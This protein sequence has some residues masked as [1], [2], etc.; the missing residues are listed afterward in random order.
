MDIGIVSNFIDEYN[1]GIGV[2]THQ[3][4]KNLGRMDT[5]NN[6]HLIHYLKNN[7]DIYSQNS[8]II[9]PKNRFVKGWGSYMFWRHFT[10]P[11]E[12]KKYNLDVV[13]DPYELGPFTFNQPFRK[14]ITVHDLTPLLFPNLFKRGDVMLHR[15]LLKKTISKAD[16]IITVSYNS[17]RDIMEYFNVPEEDIEVIYNGKGE[18][19]RQLNSSQV[20]EVKEKYRLPPRFILSVGGLHPIK[21]IPRLLEAYYLARKDGLEHKLVMVG[22]AVDRAG[23]IFQIITT[24]GL[25]DHVIFTGVVPDDDLVGLYNAADLFLYPCLYA[26][27]GLPPLEAMACGTPVITSCSSSLPEIVGDAAKLINPY[28]T[29]KLASAI[30]MVLSDDKTMKKLIKKGLK[31]AERFN[32]RKTAGKTLKVYNEVYNYW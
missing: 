3:I 31:R 16:K 27:F 7:L 25:E 18:N 9:I 5:E 12:L 30:N 13:H 19:F 29:E 17:Q 26:G 11:R 20:A 32:W 24:L 10:L 22:G 14:V 2:Y 21:N 23:E 4:V 15:L 28:D 8:E 6:Y 1:G